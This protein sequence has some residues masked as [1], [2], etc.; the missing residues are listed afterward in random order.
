MTKLAYADRDRWIADPGARARA[1]RRRC[2]TRRYAARAAARRSTRRKAQALRWRRSGRRHHRLRGRRRA[3]QRAERDPEPLQRRSARAWSPPG[4]GVVLQNRGR[5][6]QHR[7]RASERASRRGKRPVPHADR[8]V[9][10]RDDAPVL[11]F[12]TMGGDGQ[13]MFHVAGA[14]QRARLRHGDPGGDRAPALR[15]RA[16]RS[17]RRP[18][19]HGAHREP[20]AR[21]GPRRRSARRATRSRRCPTCSCGWATRTASRSRDGT[22]RGGADPRGDGAALGLLMATGRARAAP[23]R[24]AVAGLLVAAG[25]PPAADWG[26]IEPGMTTDRPGARALRRAQ[27]GDARQGARATTR[28][29]GCTRARARRAASSA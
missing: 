20:R 9:V 5:L 29:S 12:A 18:S 8:L 4:T 17:G 6:L 15:G 26:G 19:D 22:L 3:G 23:G 1:G 10:T 27:Q 2:S 28:C 21:G 25:G 13:A 24:L 16:D 14:H 7:S 11:G